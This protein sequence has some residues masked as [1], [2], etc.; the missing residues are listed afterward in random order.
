MLNEA[1]GEATPVLNTY[2]EHATWQELKHYISK[3]G[4]QPP[5]QIG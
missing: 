2:E 3:E 1:A 4:P 5:F